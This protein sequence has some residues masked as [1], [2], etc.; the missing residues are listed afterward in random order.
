MARKRTIG[1]CGDLEKNGEALTEQ[2]A[3]GIGV[4]VGL[5]RSL[6]H[7]PLE[8]GDVK[9][10]FF[11]RVFQRGTYG[12]RTFFGE[13]AVELSSSSQWVV[14]LFVIA[15][16]AVLGHHL[17]LNL[18]RVDVARRDGKDGYHDLILDACG[19]AVWR[20]E[21][22]VRLI[23]VHPDTRDTVVEHLFGTMK[24]V[25][26][27]MGPPADHGQVLVLCTM[28]HW[29]DGP[30]LLPRIHVAVRAAG[31]AWH[32]AHDWP[33]QLLP[34]AKVPP[35]R[36]VLCPGELASLEVVRGL[37]LAACMQP[38]LPSPPVIQAPV[39]EVNALAAA[40]AQVPQP[41]PLQAAAPQPEPAQV[42]APQPGVFVAHVPPRKGRPDT[43]PATFDEVKE[44]VTVFQARPGVCAVLVLDYLNIVWSDNL[45]VKESVAS[46][47]GR[48]IALTSNDEHLFQLE[49][50]LYRGVRGK[51]PWAATLTVLEHVFNQCHKP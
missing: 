6:M 34:E 20:G 43:R 26:Q 33:V 14:V 1:E 37:T 2:R 38:P 42:A 11:R 40:P 21:V 19:L 50:D 13:V 7:P 27:D 48:H 22:K 25:V 23:R 32:G 47:R 8:V 35:R 12:R 45:H 49:V 24:G 15:I 44:H 36:A 29:L 3:V 31:G 51:Q 28:S 9:D 41:G 4:E 5:L 16:R 17:G 30:W 46:W 39:P 10:V 18:T